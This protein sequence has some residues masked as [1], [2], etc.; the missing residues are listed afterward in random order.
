MLVADE[1]FVRL[2]NQMK[3]LN[4][5]TTSQSNM[6]ARGLRLEYKDFIINLSTVTQSQTAKGVI[7][8]V[9]FPLES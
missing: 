2:M 4:A 7:L 5:F 6:L 8:E 3:A 1:S 9:N